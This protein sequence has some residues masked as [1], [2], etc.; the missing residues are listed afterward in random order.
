[1]NIKNIGSLPR[2]PLCD[3]LLSCDKILT[4]IKRADGVENL[5]SCREYRCNSHCP[6]SHANKDNHCKH[7]IEDILTYYM[8]RYEELKW[9]RMENNED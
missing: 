5:F 3:L 7:A 4:I 2:C 9:E 6:I 1:M 8:N